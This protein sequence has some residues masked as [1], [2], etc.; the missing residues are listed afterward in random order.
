MSR[1]DSI[2]VLRDIFNALWYLVDGY[3]GPLEIARFPRSA[4]STEN[5]ESFRGSAKLP[6]VAATDAIKHECN[7]DGARR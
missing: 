1:K 2:V 4:L 3:T 7:S 6:L 5:C